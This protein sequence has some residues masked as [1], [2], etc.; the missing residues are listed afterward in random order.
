MM[1][2]H[3]GPQSI[4]V[5]LPLEKGVSPFPDESLSEP[6]HRALEI[7]RRGDPGTDRALMYLSTA[8]FLRHPNPD[9]VQKTA[10]FVENN[11][12][13][14]HSPGRPN[15]RHLADR[16]LLAGTMGVTYFLVAR[17]AFIFY[18][19]SAQHPSLTLGEPGCYVLPKKDGGRV[20]EYEKG[21]PKDRHMRSIVQ[22]VDAAERIAVQTR[23]PHSPYARYNSVWDFE[24]ARR[25]GLQI[26]PHYRNTQFPYEDPEHP[27]HPK[28]ICQAGTQ[29]MR[30][31]MHLILK[32]ADSLPPETSV[33]DIQLETI[34]RIEAAE[35]AAQHVRELQRA[36]MGIEGKEHDLRR[37][38][39]GIGDPRMVKTNDGW[40]FAGLEES[41]RN[42]SM[43]SGQDSHEIPLDLLSQLTPAH[44]SSIGMLTL[45]GVA[46]APY[47]LFIDRMHNGTEIAAHRDGMVAMMREYERLESDMLVGLPKVERA[48]VRISGNVAEKASAYIQDALDDKILR[49]EEECTPEAIEIVRRLNLAG[50]VSPDDVNTMVL[51]EVMVNELY[52]QL[53]GSALSGR[54][55][56]QLSRAIFYHPSLRLSTLVGQDPSIDYSGG[57]DVAYHGTGK[58]KY[59][60]ALPGIG[61]EDYLEG[62]H[63]ISTLNISAGITLYPGSRCLDVGYHRDPDDAIVQALAVDSPIGRKFKSP[64]RFGDLFVATS[65][66]INALYEA[67][68]TLEG[69]VYKRAFDSHEVQSRYNVYAR[70]TASPNPSGFTYASSECISKP[71]RVRFEDLPPNLFELEVPGATQ[72]QTESL[73]EELYE[74]KTAFENPRAL[75]E[76]L[77]NRT[78]GASLLPLSG[79]SPP[80]T[81]Y[82]TWH[83]PSRSYEVAPISKEDAMHINRQQFALYRRQGRLLDP[84]MPHWVYLPP[85]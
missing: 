17:D 58:P 21:S 85:R 61:E 48:A 40:R 79:A 73:L 62:P 13:L 57:M 27:L 22:L 60:S 7:V 68:D 47:T 41:P 51:D 50:I 80:Q 83:A 42:P 84:D 14:H 78:P 5:M 63:G 36:Y 38:R 8:W 30:N 12:N 67:R 44:I 19:R 71:T 46:N 65:H 59:L 18:L 35:V 55:G 70:Y 45:L 53:N 23:D 76:M 66:Q 43:C 28:L 10:G 1:T 33:A 34:K 77:K 29:F 39:L 69:F 54:L 2:T 4:P 52:K 9:D 56:L 72:Q 75:H 11:L 74:Q 24:I 20:E 16:I 6:E 82:D 26:V 31:V 64:R 49:V 37:K 15:E 25:R 3:E 32:T 81:N